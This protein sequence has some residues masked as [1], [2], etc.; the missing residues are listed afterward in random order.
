MSE[1]PAV[2]QAGE[3]LSNIEFRMI[4]WISKEAQV[5]IQNL[6]GT[7]W[8]SETD[9]NKILYQTVDCKGFLKKCFLYK[10]TQ[11]LLALEWVLNVKSAEKKCV[12]VRLQTNSY[13][14]QSV[15][16]GLH[17]A[18]SGR[19]YE[20]QWRP[21]EAKKVFREEQTKYYS[22]WQIWLIEC[23]LR[24]KTS[25]LT[26]ALTSVSS[27]LSPWCHVAVKLAIRLKWL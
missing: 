12:I 11:E 1:S 2:C 20:H 10:M 6:L 21:G 4:T 23:A 26:T 27:T 8:T 17:R 19:S 13:S 25:V 14:R 16:F 24:D 22:V 18:P 9:D 3:N 15:Y 5:G 7:Q